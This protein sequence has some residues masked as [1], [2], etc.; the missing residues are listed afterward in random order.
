[1][2]DCGLD[3]GGEGANGVRR[4]RHVPPAKE[5]LALLGGDP[6]HDRLARPAPRRIL[7]Q[8][9]RAHAVG[10]HRGQSY[11]K[12]RALLCKKIVGHLNQYAGPVA[13]LRV[14]AAGAPM[15]QIDE[16]LEP[17]FDDGVGLGAVDIGHQAHAARRVLEP[18][19]VQTLLGGSGQMLELVLARHQEVAAAP[20]F[21]VAY[22]VRLPR[23]RAVRPW[24][25]RLRPAARGE[26]LPKGSIGHVPRP[27]RDHA[28]SGLGVCPTAGPMQRTNL[29]AAIIVSINDGVNSPIGSGFHYVLTGIPHI[30]LPGSRQRT[31]A[32]REP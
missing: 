18:W 19:V 28:D 9:G 13:R 15:P 29:E 14:G 26:S 30:K 11:P 6:L 10:P 3:L 31:H 22:R 27:S 16:H 23:D 32:R 4:D 8:K 7:R 1:M 17:L 20:F 5:C 21:N 12:L 25:M 24:P 2:P